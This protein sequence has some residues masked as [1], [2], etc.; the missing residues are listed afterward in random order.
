MTSTARR[1]A[2]LTILF[3]AAAASAEP[4]LKISNVRLGYPAGP[5]SAG[6]EK[7]GVFKAAA[8]APVFFDLSAAEKS[9][10]KEPLEV[11]VE[12]TDADDVTT[13]ARV[14]IAAPEPGT[15]AA[16]FDLGPVAYLKPGGVYGDVTVSVRG[17]ASN[18]S[19]ADPVKRSAEGVLP[20]QYFVLGVGTALNGFAVAREDGTEEPKGAAWLETARVTDPAQLPDQWF[21]YAAADLVVLATGSQPKFWT[22]LTGRQ[23]A[24]RRAALAEWVRRGGHLVVS[25]AANL[26]LLDKL[27]EIADLLPAKASP[28]SAVRVENVSPPLPGGKSGILSAG[29]GGA[30]FAVAT[31][32]LRP[33]RPTRVLARRGPGEAAPPV[34]VQGPAG[35]G[36]VT[37]VAFDLDAPPFVGWADGPAFWRWLIEEAGTA[38]PKGGEAKP[39]VVANAD[40]SRDEYG[41]LLQANLDFFEGVPV[42]SFGWV[43]LFILLYI[44]LI[45]P[46]DYFLLKKVFKK[47]E[48]TWVTFPAI[49]IAVSAAAYFAA[50]SLKGG[51]LKVNK[52]DVVEFDLHGG[53]LYGRTWL[54][55]FSPRIQNY[56]VAV[57]PA[58]TPAG[59]GETYKDAVASWHGKVRN[60]KANLFRRSY[61]YQAGQDPD[62]P[63]RELFATGLHEVPIQVWST[64]SFVADWSA[65]L[66]PERP[67]IEADLF[68]TRTAGG[69]AVLSGK[70]TSHLPVESFAD[71]ALVWRGGVYPLDNLRPGSERAITIDKSQPFKDWLDAPARRGNIALPTAKQPYGSP[72]AQAENP[73]FRMYRPMFHD[74]LKGSDAKWAANGS[75]RGLDRSWRVAPENDGEAVFVARVGTTEGPAEATA[76]AASNP[77]KLWLNEIPADKKPRTPLKGFLRQETYIRAYIPVKAAKK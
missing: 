51:D 59:A 50:Y 38:L 63:D 18:K 42:V 5:K 22:E 49:V 77:S 17:V 12:T 23:H 45:G 68:A 75:L 53:R 30:K 61:S 39:S 58:W 11:A 54:T 15:T 74:L 26:D 24:R 34:V 13:V 66:D 67:P 55:A 27:P 69:E 8:W 9:E 70:L 43:A 37:F 44:I 76:V 20:T 56:S 47:M 19:L 62:D 46:V 16:S 73:N 64:K 7:A 25:A 71:A 60:S 32:V 48:W 21:G 41:P 57:E 52:L 33:D 28:A 3:A 2:P 40:D 31:P 65:R 72:D 6:G 29:G 10:V 14:R 1:I 35:L 36:K 4:P